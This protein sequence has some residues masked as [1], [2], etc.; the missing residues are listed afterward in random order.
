MQTRFLFLS[1]FGREIVTSPFSFISA[2][3]GR[4]ILVF[5]IFSQEIDGV[6]LSSNVCVATI[7]CVVLLREL[8]LDKADRC[9]VDFG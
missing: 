5:A 3:S 2:T 7:I 9:R 8:V 6:L 4:F 1:Q